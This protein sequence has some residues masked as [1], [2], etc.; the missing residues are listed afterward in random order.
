MEE[1]TDEIMAL[2][3]DYTGDTA[4]ISPWS[5]CYITG[6]SSVTGKIA[7]KKCRELVLD[8]S[9]DDVM[10]ESVTLDDNTVIT[11]AQFLEACDKIRLLARSIA[12]L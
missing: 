6:A 2:N 1:C 7:E 8:L 5:W 12:V 9:A 3:V 10:N 4:K 11:L